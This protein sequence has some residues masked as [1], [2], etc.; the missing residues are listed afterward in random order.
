MSQTI[1]FGIDLGTTNSVLAKF[2]N[3]KVK[4]FK[5]IISLKETVPSVVFFRKERI[6]IGTKAKERLER[7][8]ANVYSS[9]KRKMGTSESYWVPALENTVSPL[10]LSA[11]I[12]KYLKSLTDEQIDSTVITIP[13]SFGTIQS[14]ATKEAGKKAGFKEVYLL[15]EPIAASLA[16]A[17]QSEAQGLEEGQWL[18]YDLGGG[19]FDVALVRIMDG[20]MKVIDH[21][22][23]NFLGGADF[24]HLIL[25]QVIIPELEKNGN[26]T[27]L[28]LEMKKATG[29]HNAA[30]FRCLNEAE[31]AKI[32]LSSSKKSEIE[33]I[34]DD[35]EGDEVDLLISIDRRQFEKLIAPVIEDTFKMIRNIMSRN[36][37]GARDLQSVI[38]VGGSTYI[39]YV[40]ERLARDLKVK[41]D[42]SIDPTSAVAIGAAYFA[43][44]K[45]KNISTEQE[46]ASKE[47]IKLQVKMAYQKTSQEKEEFFLAKVTGEIDGLYYRITR[48]DGGFDTG[49]KP[50]SAQIVEDLPLVEHAYNEFQLHVLDAQSNSVPTSAGKI[51]ITHGKFSIEGQPLPF[52]ICIEIDDPDT[53][54]TRLE[55]IFQKNW[56][57]PVRST[58]VFPLKRAIKE[59]RK[60]DQVLINIVEGP[61]YAMPEACQTI[62]FIKITGND[63]SRDIAAESDLEITFKM[64][65]SR[66]L[67]VSAYLTMTDQEFTHVFTPTE[68]HTPVDE[69]QS[70]ITHLSAKLRDEIKEAEKYEDYERAQKLTELIGN[71][72][73]LK[74]EI[75]E[76]TLEDVTDKRYQLEDK[77]RKLALEVDKIT[78]GK[79]LHAQRKEYHDA[80]EWGSRIIRNYGTEEERTRFH[81]IKQAE[82]QFLYTDSLAKI[83]EK[84]EELREMINRIY[85][86][87]PDLLIEIYHFYASPVHATAYSNPDRA[88]K[89]IKEGREA[90]RNQD[91]RGL[92]QV[93]VGLIGIMPFQMRGGFG[94]GRSVGF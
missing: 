50:L 64:S 3:G 9:F 76:V 42:T 63:V 73:Q 30:Y 37:L 12:L 80:K 53:N 40:R 44:T 29:K 89:L 33:I 13:A 39:P 81:E 5:D 88:Q 93:N 47:E 56:V 27:D 25:D 67:E 26:F 41:V 6:V 83:K 84:N 34:M 1:N 87:T 82:D 91:W 17:N 15:Q 11:H 8:A 52:D 46:P 18:V 59:G 48:L 22:G 94:S 38:L 45:P 74:K 16:Y 90:I 21:E 23:N 60:E 28:K 70:Q 35:D 77:K 55:V 68:R 2:E 75:L 92:S 65:E 78:K 86:R 66:D 58:K 7:D 72:Q 85:W 36:G 61:S 32:E 62:G 69:L 43:G 14:N 54:G 19:T 4:I 71:M 51:S 31:K 79:Q 24:D 49:L 20:E 10:E 57:L